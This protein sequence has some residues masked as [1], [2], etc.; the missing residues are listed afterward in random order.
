MITFHSE[1]IQFELENPSDV[2]RWIEQAIAKENHETGNIDYIFCSDNYLLELNKEH[3]NHDTYT[4]IITFNYCED[5]VVSSDIF[6]SIDRVKENAKTFEVS[7]E[8]ELNRVMI[9]G[10][11]HLVGY[12]DKTE[13][14][15]QV[16]RSKEDFYLS[17]R[18][19]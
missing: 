8:N 9:H 18:S 5:N 15:Q 13:A 16:M 11:L 17:L 1:S 10:I 14:E 12:N 7:F 4:D 3:L 6:V 19:N 2:A